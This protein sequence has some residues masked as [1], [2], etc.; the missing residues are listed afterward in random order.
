MIL[1][2]TIPQKIKELIVLSENERIYY[3]VPFDIGS[4][5][6]W[7]KGSYLVVTTARVIVLK[8]GTLGAVYQIG[9]CTAAK[10][11]PRVGG[12]LLTLTHKGVEKIVVHYSAKHLSRYAYIARGINILI[13]GRFEEVES[14]EYEKTCPVCGCAIPGTKNCPKCSKEGGF[15]R[16]FTKMAKPYKKDFFGIFILMILAAV[17]TLL[18]PELQKYLINDVLKGDGGMKKA[19]VFLALMF[20]LSVG[21]VIVNILKSNASAKLG[22]KI[23]ADLRSKLF[24]KYQELPI[25]FI[26][27]RRPGELLNRITGDTM[28]IRMFMED[29]F[30]NLFAVLFIFIWD[31]IFMM[32]LNIRLSLIT[33][34]FIPLAVF[35]TMAFRKTVNR[36]FR[37]QFRKNDDVSS[38][39]QDVISGMRVVKTYGKEK[40][41]AERF[42]VLSADFARIQRRNETFWACFSPLLQLIMGLGVLAVVLFGGKDVLAGEMSPG[43]L[44]QFIT[45]TS[46][47]FQ[48]I[49]WMNRLPLQLA[50]LSACLDRMN[51]ILDQDVQEQDENAV[52]DMRIKGEIT[53]E[54]AT[55][56]YKSYQPILEDINVT[57][58]PGEMIGIVGASG[59]GKSTLINLLMGLYEVDDGRL[60]VDGRDAKTIGKNCYHS[61]IGVV[62]QETF[63][64]SGTILEN[65]RFSK[66]DATYEEV[67][68]AAKMANAHDFISET[69]NGYNTYVGE[70]G[71][72]LS[73]GERQ[74]IAIARAILTDPRLLILDEATASLDTESEYMIQKA[75]ARLTDGKTTFAIAH[76]LSTLKNADRIMVIDRHHI[77]EIGSHEELLAK[78]GIYYRLQMAQSS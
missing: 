78:K 69:P 7:L 55:F 41:E 74:R 1:Q 2:Y 62:L 24:R 38:D 30:C 8:E 22:A 25:S 18:N 12:G 27:D 45:Y 46:L 4:E 23:S 26:N 36:I 32:V 6:E 60:L 29:V 61:Q 3:A 73:G 70:K 68:R 21:I 20:S 14:R 48:Y 56:G 37:L 9:D 76:R 28:Y 43:E 13:S 57:V 53:F 19:L 66:P 15:F 65:I 75:L 59:A 33:F 51:D 64:F 16:S 5:G 40:T 47:L 50:Q 63:L 35:L 77:A 72:S 11:N 39:L 42:K 17:T 31:V 49:S 34:L 58:K 54:H 67:I 44:Y 71:Y 10:A 52:E